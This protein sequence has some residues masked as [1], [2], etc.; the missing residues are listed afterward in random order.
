[1]LTS[2]TAELP[3]AIDFDDLVSVITSD[4]F[5]MDLEIINNNYP[6]LKARFIRPKMLLNFEDALNLEMSNGDIDQ[7]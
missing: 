4:F 1:M 2:H 6:L 7:I 5:T 3:Q